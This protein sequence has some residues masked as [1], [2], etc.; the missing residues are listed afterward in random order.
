MANIETAAATFALISP[1]DTDLLL[2]ILQSV[3]LGE[4]LY[5]R[6]K[7]DHLDIVAN[8]ETHTDVFIRFNICGNSL[9]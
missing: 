3:N 1:V 5:Y 6:S 2:L 4:H 9:K 7:N 8:V